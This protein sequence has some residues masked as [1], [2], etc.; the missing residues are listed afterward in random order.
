M[1]NIKELKKEL[2]KHFSLWVKLSRSDDDYVRCYTCNSPLR[3]GTIDC[4]AGHWLPKKSCSIHYFEPD[5]VRPTCHHC[6]CFLMGNSKIFK[7]KLIEEIGKSRVDEL[8]DTRLMPACR[9]VE[10]YLE[11]IDKYKQLNKQL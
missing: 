1:K 7:E 8:Y 5:N 9:D 2:W 11:M 3:I 10:W 6:N 4:Q